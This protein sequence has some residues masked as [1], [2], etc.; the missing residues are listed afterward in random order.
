MALE[1]L[2]SLTEKEIAS[3]Y[4][5]VAQSFESHPLFT[6]VFQNIKT[7]QR[8]MEIYFKEYIRA[9]APYCTFYADSIQQNCVM[10]VFDSRKYHKVSYFF[11]IMRMCIKMTKMIFIDPSSFIQ[12]VKNWDV[13]TSRWLQDFTQGAYLH[14]DLL[15]TKEAYRKQGLATKM[16]LEL[17]RDA[18]ELGI[19]I[20]ME[21]HD[22]KCL[23]FYEQFGFTLMNT[24]SHPS[25]PLRQYCLIM[26]NKE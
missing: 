22:E 23:S 11:R 21:T 12:L 20:T 26:I 16:M 4:K 10:I 24:I 13:F 15:Y 2:Y 3:L 6:L 19:N 1:N 14:L 8:L 17:I 7:R 9:I 5:E 18:Q 25:Y